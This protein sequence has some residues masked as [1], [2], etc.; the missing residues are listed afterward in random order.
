MV[1][2]EYGKGRLPLGI[3]MSAIERGETVS[4]THDDTHHFFPAEALAGAIADNQ[5]DNEIDQQ[6]ILVIPNHW[7]ETTQQ[8]IL[9]AFEK[10]NLKCKLLWR[11]VSSALEWLTHFSKQLEFLHDDIRVNQGKLLCIHIGY[12]S[13]EITELDLVIKSHPKTDSESIVLPARRRPNKTERIPSFG[14]RWAIRNLAGKMEQI[15]GKANQVDRFTWMWNQLWCSRALKETA[16]GPHST[17]NQAQFPFEQDV[18]SV[19]QCNHEEVQQ[20]LKRRKIA[21]KTDYTG[22]VITGAFANQIFYEKQ[23]VWQWLTQTLGIRS[24]LLLVEGYDTEPGLL[25]RGALGFEYRYQAELPT[26]LDTLPLLQMVVSENG[27][28]KWIDLLEPEHKWVD[29]GRLW[30]RPETIRNLSISAHSVDLKLAIA[31]EEFDHVREVITDL[32]SKSNQTEKVSLSVE[33]APAQGKAR[34]EIIPDREKYFEGKRVFVDW[35]KMDNF[36]DERG[37]PTDKQGYLN[38]LPRIFP[39]LL[40]RIQSS[41]KWNA[42]EFQMNSV[43]EMMRR[44]ESKRSVDRALVRL[45]EQ[46]RDKDQSKYPQD[47]T[48]FDSDGQ[49]SS[50]FDLDQFMDV[51]WPYYKSQ[52]PEAFVRAIAYTHVDHKDFHEHLLA[53]IQVS[54]VREDCI[55]AAGKCFRD[56]NHIAAFFDAVFRASDAQRLNSIWWKAM[57][58]LL[59]FRANA[60][61]A[62]SSLQCEELIKIAQRKFDESVNT[63][64]GGETFRLVSLVIVYTLRRRAFDD[65]FLDPESKLALQIKEGFRKARADAKSG[66]LRLIGGS[67][68]LSQQLQLIIDY[69]DRRGKG[70]LLIGE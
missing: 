25:A 42:A 39:E 13:I 45:R 28:P 29:G 11:P 53:Q 41:S 24:Q 68:D 9:D 48:A 2:R 3:V 23:L 33:M 65:S 5:K 46:L 6:L 67:V 18:C 35:R 61:R 8:R 27:E 36:L 54:S 20:Y 49:C 4:W 64:N 32:P 51:A 47:A 10:Y 57:S 52:S 14:Y 44:N 16:N 12:D 66:R 30:R 21:L 22:L 63:G 1:S 55:V 62:I 50:Y 7:T 17:Q 38:A 58:E 26:Y 70:Q 31:H 60:T 69:I 59:R 56:P 37:N 40:P 19:E 43:L 15:Q 34:I